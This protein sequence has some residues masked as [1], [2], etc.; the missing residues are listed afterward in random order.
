MLAGLKKFPDSSIFIT[1]ELITM[2][3]KFKKD[4]INRAHVARVARVAHVTA[5]TQKVG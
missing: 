3:L 5:N 2:R 4:N 1:M